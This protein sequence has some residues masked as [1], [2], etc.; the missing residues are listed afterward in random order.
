MDAK[1]RRQ[2][3][4]ALARVIATQHEIAFRKPMEETKTIAD[5]LLAFFEH[6]WVLAVL[7]LILTVLSIFYIP[8]LIGC[9]ILIALAFHRVGVV[10]GSPVLKVQLPAYSVLC[11]V[12][13]G[14]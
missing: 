13:T 6:G 11:V 8:V 3:R 5:K 2:F 1:Q 10:K 12:L 14:L 4:R 7:G 9:G